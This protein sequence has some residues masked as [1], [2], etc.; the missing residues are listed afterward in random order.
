MNTLCLQLDG[1]YKTQI[2]LFYSENNSDFLNRPPNTNLYNVADHD[3]LPDHKYW[4]FNDKFQIVHVMQLHCVLE[5]FIESKHSA[6]WR[7]HRMYT[8]LVQDKAKFNGSYFWSHIPH[9]NESWKVRKQI[10]IMI[11]SD[12][13]LIEAYFDQITVTIPN[14]LRLIWKL[15]KSCVA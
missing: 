9:Y 3:P 1:S 14:A 10:I 6:Y 2:L 7:L 15:V 12:T 5:Q 13:S 8:A 4:S 11:W